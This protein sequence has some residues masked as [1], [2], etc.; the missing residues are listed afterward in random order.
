MEGTTPA[1]AVMMQDDT[2][3]FRTM[4]RIDNRRARLRIGKLALDYLSIHLNTYIIKI[5][6]S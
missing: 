3:Y 2:A 1:I 6:L 4:D 5:K